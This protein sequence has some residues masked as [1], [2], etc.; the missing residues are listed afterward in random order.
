MLNLLQCFKF[1]KYNLHLYL[2]KNNL[3]K[4]SIKVDEVNSTKIT[5]TIF[6]INNAEI[7]SK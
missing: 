2:K 1:S 4:F 7:N 5:L 3:T 6:S